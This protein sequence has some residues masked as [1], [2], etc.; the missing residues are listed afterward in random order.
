MSRE[1]VDSTLGQVTA[2]FLLLGGLFLLVGLVLADLPIGLCAGQV[3]RLL[4][5][6][7]MLAACGQGRRWHLSRA[8]RLDLQPHRH[9]HALTICPSNG[10]SRRRSC[11]VSRPLR[12]SHAYAVYAVCGGILMWGRPRRAAAPRCNHAHAS[13]ARSPTSS[14]V[15]DGSAA[16]RGECVATITWEPSGLMMS[17]SDSNRGRS[18]TTAPRARR[19]SRRRRRRGGCAVR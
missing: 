1:F 14:R 12:W 8:C 18:G 3:G 11:Q 10:P 19:G 17:S 13:G 16:S 6:W 2:Q 9:R 7:R 5:R 4:V 15:A